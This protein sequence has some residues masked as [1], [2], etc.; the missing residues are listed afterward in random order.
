M[1]SSVPYMHFGKWIF[2]VRRNK[3]RLAV[4]LALLAASIAA[5][6]AWSPALPAVVIINAYVIWGPIAALATKLGILKAPP[7]PEQQELKS[8]A[9]GPQ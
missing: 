7:S 2:S 1:V 5:G 8:G 6:I 4:L 9:Q 3:Q